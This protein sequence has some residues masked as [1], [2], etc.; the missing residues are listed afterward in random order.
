MPDKCFFYSCAKQ[1]VPASKV[2]PQEKREQRVKNNPI[3]SYHSNHN[4]MAKIVARL[5]SINGV[6]V[7]V[8]L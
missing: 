7:I 1:N 4:I 3:I 8:D 5:L 6:S 2:S